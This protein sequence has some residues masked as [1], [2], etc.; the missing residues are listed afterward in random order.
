MP[1][2]GVVAEELIEG[3][4]EGDAE[5]FIEGVIEGDTEGVIEEFIGNDTES[6]AEDDNEDIIE[7][8]ID[9]VVDVE[10]LVFADVLALSDGEGLELGTV[11]ALDVSDGRPDDVPIPLSVTRNQHTIQGKRY[12]R[13]KNHVP[14]VVGVVDWLVEDDRHACNGLVVKRTG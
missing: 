8:I 1:L 5:E 14:L 11:A 7:D 3:V 6:D 12:V 10:L 2:S 9:S 4:I 13:R